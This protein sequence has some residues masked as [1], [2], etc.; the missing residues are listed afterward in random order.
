M[1]M[2]RAFVFMVG[3]ILVWIAPILAR[4]ADAT[5]FDLPKQIFTE[6]GIV[7][8]LLAVAVIY[9]AASNAKTKSAWEDDRK[10][11]AASYEKLATS[12]ARLEG[13]ILTLQTR[14]NSGGDR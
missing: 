3:A 11:M 4:A 5:P 13:M 2:F 12:N 10:I 8:G 6:C 9:L 7:S 1:S 14:G